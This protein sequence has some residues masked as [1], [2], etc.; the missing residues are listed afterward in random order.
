[1]R[2][3]ARGSERE[4]DRGWVRELLWL[5]LLLLCSSIATSLLLLK[6]RRGK[7]RE[8]EV[9][10]EEVGPL[11]CW[12]ERELFSKQVQR[13]RAFSASRDDGGEEEETSEVSERFSLEFIPLFPLLL[14]KW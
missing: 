3:W 11:Q 9:E 8:D 14:P 2:D 10:R 4:E 13:E 12:I 1:M 6:K 7:E 5:L